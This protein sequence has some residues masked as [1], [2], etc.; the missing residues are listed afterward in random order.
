MNIVSGNAPFLRRPR[1]TGHI[2]RELLIGL[3]VIFVAAV[4]YN[5]TLGVNYGFKAIGIMVVSILFTLISDVIAGSLRF[6]KEK[7][8]KYEDFMMFFIKEN[9]SLVTG[10]IFAL[11][12]PIGTPVYVIAVGSIFATLIVKHAFGGFGSN[13]FNP[14]ALGRLFL[15]LAFGGQLKAYLPGGENLGGLNAGVT[16]TS[17]FASSGTKFLTGTLPSNVKMLDLW[18]G[19]YSG[20]LGETFALLILVVGVVLAAREVINWRTP[21]FLIGTVFLSSVFMALIGQVNVL[22]YVL[23]QFGLG[24]ILFGAVFMFTDPVTSPTSNFGKALIGVIGGFFNLLI[25]VAGIYPEGTA[26]SIALVNVFVPMIDKSIGGRTDTKLWKPY[27]VSAVAVLLTVGLLSGISAAKGP[28]MPSEDSSTS[29]TPVGQYDA[30]KSLLDVTN[31]DSKRTL[32]LSAALSGAGVLTKEEFKYEGS[33]VGII[34]VVEIDA[35]HE[36]LKFEVGFKAD[37]YAGFNVLVTNETPGIGGRFLDKVDGLIKGELASDPVLTEQ[38]DYAGAT[39]TRDPLKDAL[40][41]VAADYLVTPELSVFAEYTG[42]YTSP[43]PQVNQSEFTTHVT[44]GLDEDYHIISV[45]YDVLSSPPT[46]LTAE[47]A[48]GLITFYTSISVADFKVLPAPML[49]DDTSGTTVPGQVGDHIVPTKMYSSRALYEAIKDALKDISVFYGE[50]TSLPRAGAAEEMTLEVNVYVDTVSAKIKTL[51]TLGGSNTPN[52]Q[53]NWDRAYPQVRALYQ[54]LD[55]A[56]F[57][58][59]QSDVEMLADG[60]DDIV[61]SVSWSPRRLFAAVQNALEG[62]GA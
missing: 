24:G 41:L 52:W 18:L 49:S 20:A 22:D 26:F 45:E 28:F 42:S 34:Y 10:V 35:Y 61:T 57:L 46:W 62:Y 30:E 56:T 37:V 50:H 43:K 13:I 9:F 21:V 15:A 12:V 27:T 47:E 19:N 3:A 11:T 44:V 60:Y 58:S 38:A 59:Y 51:E 32:A 7:D 31:I 48:A 53:E 40:E 8:G 6:N 2:M 14:A 17:E 29:E 36:G 23:L 5:F 39:L 33:R 4:V 16:V 54:D 1:K 55:V 25:R